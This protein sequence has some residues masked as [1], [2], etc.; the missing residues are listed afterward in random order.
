MLLF[1][2]ARS[3]QRIPWFT[4]VSIVTH[5]FSPTAETREKGEYPFNKILTVELPLNFMLY[6]VEKTMLP[7]EIEKQID[8]HLLV[9][10]MWKMFT[11]SAKVATDCPV[12]LHK[13]ET[14]RMLY[15]VIKENIKTVKNLLNVYK[16][17]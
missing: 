7:V 16:I 3:E 6:L 8:W 4:Q 2:N 12:V 14:H 11:K 9:S 17:I 13:H 5:L 15:I 10:A 1:M